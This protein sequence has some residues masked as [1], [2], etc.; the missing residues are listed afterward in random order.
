MLIVQKFI[1]ALGSDC[2]GPNFLGTDISG[3]EEKRKD[4]A[5]R[6]VWS[7]AKMWKQGFRSRHSQKLSCILGAVMRGLQVMG[8][9]DENVYAYCSFHGHSNGTFAQYY[10]QQRIF[11]EIWH[12][13][14]FM[15]YS[16]AFSQLRDML[17]VL[18][19]FKLWL[20]WNRIC[21]AKFVSAVWKGHLKSTTTKF[22]IQMVLRAGW[23]ALFVKYM[24]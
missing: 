6:K 22:L 24:P 7:F 12:C 13:F 14:A 16:Y 1:W 8:G 15:L 3:A 19:A 10:E 5:Y 21:F 4:V 2:A 20:I 18:T 23:S 11:T 9:R 17:P